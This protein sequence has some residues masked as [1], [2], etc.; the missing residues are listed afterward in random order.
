MWYS[1]RLPTF[2]RALRPSAG[3]TP[4]RIS[5]WAGLSAWSFLE[6]WRVPVNQLIRRIPFFVRWPLYYA[7]IILIGFYGKFGS[8]GFIYQQ[9]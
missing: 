1:R 3:K 5:F 6:F 8:S 2:L 4:Y 9:Y 7:L